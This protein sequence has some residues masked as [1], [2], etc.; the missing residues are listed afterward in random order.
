M[1]D[2]QDPEDTLWQCRPCV[3][4]TLVLGAQQGQVN[5]GN[6]SHLLQCACKGRPASLCSVPDHIAVFGAMFVKSM[7]WPFL[8][9][10][11]CPSD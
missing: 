6:R 4:K 10:E 7:L 2:D 11:E 9:V 8:E 5:G 1:G 3:C